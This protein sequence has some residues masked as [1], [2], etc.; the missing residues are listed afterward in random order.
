MRSGGGFRSILYAWR[1]ARDNRKFAARFELRGDSLKRAPQGYAPDHPLIEDLKRKDFIAV[2]ELDVD[3]V[4]TKDFADRVQQSF[5][6]TKPLMKFLCEAQ[7]L[8]F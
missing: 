8:A 6:S 5:M 7:P 2:E 1:K 3:E 4:L